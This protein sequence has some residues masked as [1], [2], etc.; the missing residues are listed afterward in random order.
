MI[1]LFSRSVTVSL[2]AKNG[3]EKYSQQFNE[4]KGSNLELKLITPNPTTGTNF[5]TNLIRF[6]LAGLPK[7]AILDF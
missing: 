6:G 7:G 1:G 3:T 4:L 2:V 5:E